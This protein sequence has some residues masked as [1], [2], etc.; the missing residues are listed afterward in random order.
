MKRLVQIFALAILVL[1]S[2]QPMAHAQSATQADSDLKVIGVK[3]WASWCGKCKQLDPKLSNVK[4]QFEG[5]PILFTQF[6]M[7]NDFTISQSK[8]MAKLLGLSDLFQKH[9]G[10]TGYMV[11]LDAQTH[12]VLTTL[13]H[14]QSEQE[15]KQQIGSVLSE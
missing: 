6:D 10:S 3:M 7:T 8:K 4:P 13:K 12:K 2:Y 5:Q 11:L 15:L 14:N 9:K 1:F